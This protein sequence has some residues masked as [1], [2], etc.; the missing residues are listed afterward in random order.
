MSWLRCSL[1][2]AIMAN[3]EISQPD[4]RVLSGERSSS[5]GTSE[6]YFVFGPF[7]VDTG[8]C[9]LFRDGREVVLRAQAFR[10]LAVLVRNAGQP[11]EYQQMVRDAWA[12]APVSRHAVAVTISEVRKVLGEH[13]S[14][15]RYRPRFG[16]CLEIPKAENHPNEGEIQVFERWLTDALRAK[17][18][19]RIMEAYAPDESLLIF[20]AHCR[21]Q[22]MGS[23]DCESTSGYS[24]ATFPRPV[25]PEWKDWRF[26]AEGNLGYAHGPFQ[27]SAADAD[28]KNSAITMWVTHVLRKIKGRWLIVHE[29]ISFPMNLQ[30]LS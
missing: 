12:G 16:F 30:S 9:R 8:S 23:E 27:T 5:S 24:L 1:T 22:S 3:I 25:R 13:G 28:G 19:S 7:R 6:G 17:D 10:A 20:E 21:R 15:I 4:H 26:S 18:V 11:V 2:A 29:H 14:W